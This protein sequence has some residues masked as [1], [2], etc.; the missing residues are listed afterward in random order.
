M[1]YLNKTLSFIILLLSC[2]LMMPLFQSCASSECSIEFELPETVNSNYRILYYASDKSKGAMLEFMIPVEN[3]KFSM[4]IPVRNPSIIYLF[5]GS[6]NPE[7]AFYAEGGDKIKITGDSPDPASWK[8]SGNDIVEEW[9][10][11]R[12]QNRD[13][14]ASRD[15]K[16]LNETVRKFVEGNRDNPLSTI[17]LLTYFSRYDDNPL[18]EKLWNSLKDDALN[19]DILDLIPR[20]DIFSGAPQKDAIPQYIA[21]TTYGNGLD[22]I[23]LSSKAS[24]LAFRSGEPESRDS[25]V[26]MLRRLSREFADSASRNIVDISFESDSSSWRH[27]IMQDSVSKIVHAWMPLGVNDNVAVS[28]AVV[29][30][31]FYIVIDKKGKSIYRG[32]SHVKASEAFRKINGK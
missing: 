19:T 27:A 2:T 9:S 6:A 16:R 3:G 1:S 26:K 7:L 31:P 11:W 32:D 10:L 20:N 17:L 12:E 23:K 30:D 24:I 4:K 15:A 28:L 22:S 18:F 14:I 29:S 25:A 13:I 5:R 8:I 21:L